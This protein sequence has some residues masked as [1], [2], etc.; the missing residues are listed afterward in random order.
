MNQ[1][2]LKKELKRV[3]MERELAIKSLVKVSSS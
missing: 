1:E 3:L 2:E